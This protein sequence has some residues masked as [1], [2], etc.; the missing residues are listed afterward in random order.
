[1][2]DHFLANKHFARLVLFQSGIARPA[3]AAV[4]S[5][6]GRDS[7][8]KGSKTGVCC[9]SPSSPFPPPTASHTT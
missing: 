6:P 7:G 2:F 8:S 4:W 1:M 3:P 9:R 5:G